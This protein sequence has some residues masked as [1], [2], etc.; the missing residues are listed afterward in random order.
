M[1]RQ[2]NDLPADLEDELQKQI[3]QEGRSFEQL[4]DLALRSHMEN[5]AETVWQVSVSTALAEGI[6]AGGVCVG[7]LVRQCNLGLGTFEHL[8]GE[9]VIIDGRVFQVLPDGSVHPAEPQMKTP[10]AVVTSFKAT[11]QKAGIDCASIGQLEQELDQLRD[12]D[13]YFYA[14]KV[15]GF[16]ESIHLRSVNRDEKGIRLVDAAAI[17]GEF[18]F[19]NLEGTLVGFWSPAF[20]RSMCI[21]GYHLHFLSAERDRGGHLLDLSG[22]NLCLEIQ[23]K[24]SLKAM[25]PANERFARADLTRDPTDDLHKAEKAMSKE[26]GC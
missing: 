10:F 12:S 21:T 4:L 24:T 3:A 25:L 18:D 19:Q 9:L 17:Q 22:K 26:S 15:S 7:E 13:N 14:L 6:H 16:F 23:R 1:S 8:D 11:R 2:V 20:S 5:C